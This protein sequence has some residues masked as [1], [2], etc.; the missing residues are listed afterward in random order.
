M[1]SL[2]GVIVLTA[3]AILLYFGMKELEQVVGGIQIVATPN[4][5]VATEQAATATKQGYQ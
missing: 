4:L 3:G 2:Y 1:P 5:S